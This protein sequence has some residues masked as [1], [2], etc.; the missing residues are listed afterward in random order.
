MVNKEVKMEE[1]KVAF[2][3]FAFAVLWFI[4][5][6]SKIR[7][8]TKCTLY[9]VNEI[10]EKIT[11]AEPHINYCQYTSPETK[12]RKEQ[13]ENSLSLIPNQKLDH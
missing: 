5:Q 7:D 4:G 10:H 2:T 8:E 1:H 9:Q 11:N 3:F 13:Y 12:R 6:I